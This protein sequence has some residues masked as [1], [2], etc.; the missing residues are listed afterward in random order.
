MMLT[1]FIITITVIVSAIAFYFVRQDEKE[2]SR[3]H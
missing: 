2:K 3:Q 1:I